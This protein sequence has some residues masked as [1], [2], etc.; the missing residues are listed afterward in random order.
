M[1]RLKRDPARGPHVLEA[2]ARGLPWKVIA[3]ELGLARSRLHDIYAAELRHK[4][5]GCRL[6]DRLHA[7][8]ER[9]V[10]CLRVTARV[11]IIADGEVI[12]D[13]KAEKGP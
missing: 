6:A 1:R 5:R 7:A 4:D 9:E 11:Q 3:R 2:R 8:I 10:Q 13:V 12:A